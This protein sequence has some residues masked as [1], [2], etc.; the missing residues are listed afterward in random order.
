MK[1]NA[2]TPILPEHLRATCTLL[3]S[4][5]PKPIDPNAYLPLL[6]LLSQVMSDHNLAEVVADAFNMAYGQVLN[7]IYRARSIDVPSTEALE[8][9]KQQLLPHGYENWSRQQ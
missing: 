6:A 5:F 4:A 1:P 7:D 8:K 9:I 2:A 3:Q